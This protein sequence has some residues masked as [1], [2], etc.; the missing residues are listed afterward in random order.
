MHSAGPRTRL[1]ALMAGPAALFAAAVLALLV[2][3]QSSKDRVPTARRAESSLWQCPSLSF[4]HTLALAFRI[5]KNDGT[6]C[7]S[8]DWFLEKLYAADPSPKG[9]VFINLGFN[10]GYKLVSMF[11]AWAPWT[12]LNASAWH[13]S[14]VRSAQQSGLPTALLCGA[15]NDCKNDYNYGGGGRNASMPSMSVSEYPL[16]IGVDINAKNVLLFNSVW[17][18]NAN[19]IGVRAKVVTAAVSDV[20]KAR[21]PVPMCDGVGDENCSLQRASVQD[22]LPPAYTLGVN[23]SLMDSFSFDDLYLQWR[24][25]G[26]ISSKKSARVDFLLVDTEGHDYKVLLGALGTFLRG[27]V[28]IV[29][30]EYTASRAVGLKAMLHLMDE[31]A[32]MDCYFMGQRRLW[33]LTAGC[34]TTLYEIHSWSNIICVKRGDLWARVVDGMAVKSAAE[35]VQGVAVTVE[36]SRKPQSASKQKSEI[37]FF[38]VDKSNGSTSRRTIA[39]WDSYLEQKLKNQPKPFPLHDKMVDLFPIIQSKAAGVGSG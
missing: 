35:H 6:A 24:R 33:Q 14:L 16:F 20:S 27:L 9:K 26:T 8:E 31:K 23:A 18:N 34:F 19:H 28:R 29:I 12:D 21:V 37:W 17:S 2:I 25:D 39:N 32:D 22:P 13:N 30:F 36:V 7:P 11:A 10:K 1:R 15:C 5:L 38:E 3:F 4:A